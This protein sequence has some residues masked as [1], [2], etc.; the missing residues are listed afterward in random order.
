M[1]IDINKINKHEI[2]HFLT[3]LLQKAGFIVSETPLNRVQG[4]SLV[5]YSQEPFYKGKYLVMYIDKV[6]LID[7]AYIEN[8]IDEAY[9]ENLNVE[10]KN[11]KANKGILMTNSSFSQKA[12]ELANDENIELINANMLNN[13]VEKYFQLENKPLTRESA[14]RVN[15]FIK[16]AEFDGNKYK[17]LVQQIEEDKKNFDVYLELFNFLYGYILKKNYKI[18]YAGLIHE[19]IDLAAEIVKKFGNKTKKGG[20]II[21]IFLAIQGVLYMLLG[22]IDKSFNIL[23]KLKMVDFNLTNFIFNLVY[24]NFYFKPDRFAYDIVY[25]KEEYKT[26]LYDYACIIYKS[27]L[28]TLLQNLDDYNNST[29]LH[30]QFKKYFES[31]KS[32]S[33]IEYDFTSRDNLSQIANKNYG[34]VSQQLANVMLKKEKKIYLPLSLKLYSSLEYSLENYIEFDDIKTYWSEISYDEQRKQI[35]LIF[36]LGN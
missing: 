21:S 13:L 20:I 35:E 12:Q 23:H 14:I 2:E 25:S 5:A 18:I 36:S 4:V 17:Y 1:R 29:Y 28:L 3:E 10:V 30:N 9:I 33:E 15:Y 6:D 31:I 16:Y 19:C 8:L 7:E 26:S 11:H 27:N 32:K 22:H 24:N 34:L